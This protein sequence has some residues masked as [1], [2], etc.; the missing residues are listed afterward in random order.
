MSV[1]VSL[2]N[3]GAVSIFG[4]VL[5]ASFSNVLYSRRNSRIFW[6][7]VI[8]ILLIQCGIYSVGDEEILRRI[9]PLI[10]HMPLILLLYVLTRSFL[11]SVISVFSAYLCCQLRR[12]PALLVVWLFSGRDIHQ[13]AVELLVT[14]PLLFI[15]L[16]FVAPAI[17]QLSHHPLKLQIQFGSIPALYYVFD[18]ATVVYTDFLT[19]GSPVAAEFMPLVCCVGYLA[20]VLYYS[21][22]ER[23]YMQLQQIQDSLDIQLKQSVREISTLRESQAL[24]RRYRH[25]LRHHLQY[26]ST[27]IQNGRIEQIQAYI[28][29]ICKEIEAQSVKYYCENETVNLIFSSFAGRAGK[30]GID[31]NICGTLPQFLL[32]SE[33]DLCVLLSNALENALHAC[34]PLAA[35]GKESCIDVQFYEKE[36]KLFLQI[37]NPYQGELHFENGVPVSEREKHGIGVQ[38]ICAIVE[39]Y[40]G[41]YSFQIRDKK[42]VLRLQL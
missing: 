35:A 42:F 18:Y 32:V 23:R 5:A 14:V 17:R 12:W 34:Q 24:A 6:G 16:H 41:L 13:D 21:A 10:V 28:S 25:D 27:G 4:S 11:W 19:S 30:E 40:Q 22:E 37:T 3:N 20:Y 8:A 33:R 7:F 2:I 26:I 39:R 31:M 9:Y 36:E 29:D 15:L 1:L 38:S